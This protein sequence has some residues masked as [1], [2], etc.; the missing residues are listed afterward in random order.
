[1]FFFF[2]RQITSFFLKFYAGLHLNLTEGLPISAKEDVFT[3]VG[4]DGMML[5]KTGFRDALENGFID[6]EEVY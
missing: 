3:L 5:G 2:K 4:S 6:Y 1:M